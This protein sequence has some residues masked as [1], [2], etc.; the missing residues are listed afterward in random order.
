MD[1]AVIDTITSKWPSLGLP[2]SGQAIW[3]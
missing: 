2:G 1:Q 3:K